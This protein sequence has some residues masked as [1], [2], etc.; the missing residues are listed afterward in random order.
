MASV[1]VSREIQRMIMEVLCLLVEVWKCCEQA[2]VGI[3]GGRWLTDG[4]ACV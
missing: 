1:E 4:E 2:E 3:A